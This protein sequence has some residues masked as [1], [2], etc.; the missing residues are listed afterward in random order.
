MFKKILVCL[1]GSEL[2]EQ[3]L[4]YVTEQALRFDS[5]VVLLQAMASPPFISS[6][7]Q[8]DVAQQLKDQYQEEVNKAKV[9]LDQ[10]ALL[11]RE[12]G[13]DVE[14]VLLQGA[15][16]EAGKYIVD[17]A[18]KNKVDII[19]IATHGRGGLKRMIFGS[20]ADFV[21]RESRLPM[22][23]IRPQEVNT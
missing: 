23:V 14:T 3:V 6:S 16:S 7:I 4:P 10:T 11:L 2:A 18:H 21:L 8:P 22:L 15:P 20:V 17:Y 19:A 13:V 9:Y 1:D 12:K 5:N